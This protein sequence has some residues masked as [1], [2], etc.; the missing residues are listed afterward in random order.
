M[1]NERKAPASEARSNID[2]LAGRTI[3][4]AANEGVTQR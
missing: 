1:T 2:V 3:T 4:G